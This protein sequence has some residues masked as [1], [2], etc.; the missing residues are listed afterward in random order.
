MGER[1]SDEIFNECIRTNDIAIG[2]LDEIDLSDKNYEDILENLGND[3]S[4]FGEK[5]TPNAIQ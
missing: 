5:P 4:E 3:S 2:W 1:K